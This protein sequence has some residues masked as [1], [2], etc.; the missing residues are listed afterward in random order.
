MM[1]F[2]ARI[3]YDNETKITQLDTDRIELTQRAS[4]SAEFGSP[5][6]LGPD[7]L[8]ELVTAAKLM[9]WDL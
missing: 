8:A 1:L 7:E 2:D 6:F 9:G 5:L 4:P 3:S